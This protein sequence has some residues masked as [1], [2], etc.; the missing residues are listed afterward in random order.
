MVIHYTLLVIVEVLL[1][2]QIL[3]SIKVYYSNNN[4][5]KNNN[6]NYLIKIIE[7]SYRSL[8]YITNVPIKNNSYVIKKVNIYKYKNRYSEK[9][10]LNKTFV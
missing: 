5:L 2:N 7:Y 9:W 4:L 1:K 6:V 8:G 3:N 10:V